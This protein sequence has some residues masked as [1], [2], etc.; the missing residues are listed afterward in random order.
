M[1]YIIYQTTNNINGKIYIGKHKTDNIDDGYLGSGKILCSAI[2]KYGKKNFS[3]K[4]LFCFDNEADA[5]NK[6]RELVTEEFCRLD[7]NYNICVGGKGGF[8]YINENKLNLRTGMKHSNE[9]KKL[10][11]EQS[12]GRK[13]SKE[14]RQKISKNNKRTNKSRGEKTSKALAGKVKSE[15]HKRK[16]AESVKKRWAKRKRDGSV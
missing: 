15:E 11:S 12:T 1:H 10:L 16:I 9:T 2:N 8:S 6:E 13:A 4:M 3:R 14:T 5:N 7:T